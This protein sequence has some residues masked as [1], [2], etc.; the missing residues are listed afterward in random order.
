MCHVRRAHSRVS[1]DDAEVEI[2]MRTTTCKDL[3]LHAE[4]F[5]TLE[6]LMEDSIFSDCEVSLQE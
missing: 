1:L 4:R 5:R 3:H 2:L 6:K